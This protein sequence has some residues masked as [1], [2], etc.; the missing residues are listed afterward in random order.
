[1]RADKVT[2][3]GYAF[4]HFAV[5]VMC[6]SVLI[7]V[8]NPGGYWWALA[9]LFD[10]L[11]FGLQAPLGVLFEKYN[12]AKPGVWGLIILSIG[13]L[14]AF[15]SNDNVI[16]QFASLI[17]I[18]L[19]N[20]MVHIA[21]ALSTLRVSEGRLS[22]SAIFVGGGS[23][24]V[25]TGRLIG[26]D[27]TLWWIPF[28]ITAVAIVMAII[29]DIRIKRKYGRYAFS[30]DIEP[31]RQKLVNKPVGITI[32]ILFLV[33]CVRAYIGY[34]LPTAW[35]KTVVQTILLFSFMGIGKMS[36]GILADIFGA[37]K[38]GVISCLVAVPML[39]FSN[40]I[41][42]LSLLGV[43]SFSMTMAITLGGLVSVL[44]KHPGVAFGVTTLGLLMGTVPLF[45]V[46]MPS[47]SVCDV[48][49]VIM[50]VLAA[51][52]LWYC[53]DSKRKGEDN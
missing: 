21:G 46:R 27:R 13:A 4:I 24:G 12:N 8:Y 1:M 6:F 26:T 19:G 10:I 31:C 29:I 49:I 3:I 44:P 52:G 14:I 7:G 40:N 39:V 15:L 20:A 17:I 34:G 30:F 25:I 50:S 23:F 45:F 51:A 28:I 38:V 5:E 41:M 37:R 18:T 22:E 2:G 48:L 42:W 36:G 33:V 35:N 9:C 53:I 16:F 11:A 43:A 32:L 47:R